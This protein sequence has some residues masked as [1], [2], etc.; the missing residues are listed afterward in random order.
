MIQHIS[1]RDLWK[2]EMDGTKEVYAYL[3]SIPMDFLT[4]TGAILS[5]IAVIKSQGTAILRKFDKDVAALIE[6]TQMELNIRGWHVPAANI[7]FLFAS[8]VGHIMGKGKPFA[9][10]FTLRDGIVTFSLR[11]EKE[12]GIDVSEVAKHFGG[13]GHRNAAGFKVDYDTF[14][15]FTK[16]VTPPAEK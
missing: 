11:S 1:D 4:W 13:G 14:L 6:S 2:F 16:K 5:D 7:P 10:T 8:E 9:A 3:S 12:G 15:E